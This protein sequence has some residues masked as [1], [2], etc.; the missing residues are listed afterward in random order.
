LKPACHLDKTLFLLMLDW[1]QEMPALYVSVC[2]CRL[3]STSQCLNF[4]GA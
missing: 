2:V 3:I 4:F 1:T